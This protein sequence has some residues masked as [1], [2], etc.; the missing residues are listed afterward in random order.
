MLATALLGLTAWTAAPHVPHDDVHAIAMAPLAGGGVEVVI[1]TNSHAKFLRSTDLGLSW[2][3]IAGD[4]LGFEQGTAVTYWDHPTDPRFFLGTTGGVWSYRP[5]SGGAV[6]VTDGLHNGHKSVTDLSSP[7]QGGGAVLLATSGGSIYGWREASS[8]WGRVLMTGNL[9][10]HAQVAV[11][12][13]YDVSG[14][15]GPDMALFAAVA[16]QLY[17]S[18]NGGQTWALSPQFNQVATA[19]T[20]WWITSITPAVNFRYG[21]QVVVGR[22]RDDAASLTGTG[23][24]LWL[25]G[26][27]GQSFSLSGATGSAVRATCATP[28][29][30][31]GPRR[32]L[33][34]LD[35]FP[36]SKD[37]PQQPGVL[38]STDG[39]AWGD[40][41]NRQDFSLEGEDNTGVEGQLADV[42][43]LAFSPL[44]PSDGV[45]FLARSSGLYRS[46]DAGRTWHQVNVR[47]ASHVRGM[48]VCLDQNGELQAFCASHGSGLVRVNLDQAVTELLDGPIHYGRS[49]EA[50]TNFALDG[51]VGVAGE[52]GVALWLDASRP[53]LT[54]AG[55]TGFLHAR[56]FPN[57]RV[58]EFHPEFDLSGT[59]PGGQKTLVWDFRN[60]ISTFLSHDGGK[61]S[62]DVSHLNTGAPAPYM[63]RLAIAP[64]YDPGSAASRTDIYGIAG[65]FLMKLSNDGWDSVADTG[66]NLLSIAL[67]PGFSRPGNPRVFV[68]DLDEPVV[69]EIIDQPGN[70]QVTALSSDGLEGQIRSLALGDDFAVRPVLYAA[71]WG[72]GIMKLDL[73]VATPVWE[74]V[75]APF[76]EAWI[77]MVKVAPGFAAD[78]RIVVGT[79]YGVYVGEDQPGAPWVAMPA[80]Y[81]LDDAATCLR[82]YDPAA[83]ANKH[84]E[85]P[86]P[87]QWTSRWDN[88]E[89]GGLELVGQ[90]VT[91]TDS[92]G[93]YLEW[94][95]LTRKVRLQTFSGTGMGQV[96][97]E[98]ISLDTGL[99]TGSVTSELLSG[100]GPAVFDVSLEVPVAESVIVRAT[101]LL[102]PG[103]QLVVDGLTVHPG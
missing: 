37:H 34:T 53:P 50:S 9:D 94:E 78:R 21:R 103:E 76:P 49:A 32:F 66:G 33:A 2:Q 83:Q 1:A 52:G 19:P 99:S 18:Q 31:A 47:S 89:L 11:A 27:H 43:D 74:P 102:D 84:P 48:D 70:V 85:R 95:C 45:L 36:H 100:A 35:A 97:L 25:S 88:A 69:Y 13:D 14:G 73:A 22:G 51:A 42:L 8:D 101:A 67:D 44:F 28:P 29:A 58:I 55:K 23:G 68:A 65:G 56:T 7:V 87:W 26:D 71:T 10:D 3:P 17:L 5:G 91:W 6:R 4:G 16:G 90:G 62:Y 96:K 15:P 54:H 46:R 98:F 57:A 30:P 20:D 12:P 79:Q 61:S 24:E 81:T 59:L 75:G 80:P 63:R 77:E 40:L 39:V 93:A 72:T 64:T 41:G 38:I 82:Y 86:W 60:P 92:D